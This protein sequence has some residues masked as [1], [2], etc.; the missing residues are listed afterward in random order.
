M[1]VPEFIAG[2]KA[3]GFINKIITRASL[4]RKI[5]QHFFFCLKKWSR[6][7]S[8]VVSSEAVIYDDFAPSD[9]Q[10]ICT[11]A[12]VKMYGFQQTDTQVNDYPEKRGTQEL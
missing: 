5:C 6:N 3:V 2:R 11:I 12:D 10:T 8:S 1:E 7:T 4:N 9:D